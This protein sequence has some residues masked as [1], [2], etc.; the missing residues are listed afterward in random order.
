MKVI[1]EPNDGVAPLVTAIRN[2]KKS[3][4]IVIFRFD[5]GEIEAQ[6]KAAVGRGVKVTALTGYTNRGGETKLRQLEMRFLDAGII[7]A[8]SA[9][10]LTRYH[11]KLLIVDRRVLYMLSFNYTH[12]D[13][14]RSRGFGIVTR[15]A[16][17]V[18]EAVKLLEA[19]STRSPYTPGLDS[20]VVSPVN[21]RQVLSSFILQA[22]KQLLIYD[23]RI[24]DKE[25][26]GI[27]Q[28]HASAGLEIRI[29]GRIDDGTNLAVKKLN[30]L[31]LHARTIIRDR[32]QVFVGSQSLRPAALDSRREVGL[33]VR[34]AKVV[35]TLTDTFESDWASAG[36]ARR[37]EPAKEPPAESQEKQAE[38]AVQGLVQDMG[39]LTNTVKK[40]V[41]KVVAKAGEEVLED[42]TVKETVKKMVR[43]VVKKA[44]KDAVEEV[45]QDAK[46]V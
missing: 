35:R 42:K 45:A 30:P 32:D 26:I 6:L 3:V 29:L 20:F 17:W 15:N 21:S 31:R 8:R 38:A 19:D 5:H 11:D 36:T 2:A 14:D 43:K 13:I 18:Q 12:A 25:M 16:K 10:D 1:V 40:A 7:V 44:V 33:I 28:D 23:P 22:K 37:P 41:K 4:E 46:K 9:D 27:L 24:S 34:D 39:P